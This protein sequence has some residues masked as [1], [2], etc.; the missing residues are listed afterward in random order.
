MHY[1]RLFE[2]P[3][4]LTV[5]G[6]LIYTTSKNHKHRSFIV[7]KSGEVWVGS[8]GE[9]HQK[10][11]ADEAPGPLLTALTG[12]VWPDLKIIS[13][14]H[15]PIFKFGNDYMR[16]LKL[17]E[18]ELKRY[19]INVNEYKVDLYAMWKLGYKD[20]IDP[21]L[22]TAY[23]SSEDS[24]TEGYKK[25]ID[26]LKTYSEEIDKRKESKNLDLNKKT[27]HVTSLSRSGSPMT[28]WDSPHNIRYRQQKWTSESFYPRLSK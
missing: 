7:F 22:E 26:R 12:R 25:F 13:F 10:M 2:S 23:E 16:Y 19:K 9:D 18:A 3:D 28:A 15:N 8:V 4:N 1:K 11:I 21:S 6:E 27:N 20:V 5:N 14:W 17:L 24:I